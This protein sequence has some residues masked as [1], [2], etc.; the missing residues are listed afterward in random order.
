MCYIHRNSPLR[1]LRVGRI[2]ADSG[3]SNEVPTDSSD[4]KLRAL[5]EHAVQ[6]HQPMQITFPAI[7][8]FY[9]HL[10]REALG[11]IP[12]DQLLFFWTGYTTFALELDTEFG[13]GV[14][15]GWSRSRILDLSEK[16]IGSTS[17]WGKEQMANNRHTTGKHVFIQIGSRKVLDCIPQVIALQ[18]EKRSGIYYRINTAEIEQTAW[19]E[20]RPRWE[21][22]TLG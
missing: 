2:F 16:T 15:L 3:T 21:I 10:A 11:D 5:L 22:I 17:W 7:E 1:L 20:I 14:N 9:P 18:V 6:G 13:F 8:S 4:D 19:E 12:D